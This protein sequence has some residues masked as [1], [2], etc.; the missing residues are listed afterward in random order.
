MDIANVCQMFVIAK[1][2]CF[3]G[4]EILQLQGEK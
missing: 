1:L 2:G 3:I 4:E